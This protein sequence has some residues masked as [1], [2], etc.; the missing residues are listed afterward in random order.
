[1]TGPGADPGPGRPNEDLE[2]TDL[3][4]DRSALAMAVLGLVLVKQL[5]PAQRAHPVV[6]WIV[7]GIASAIALVGFAYRRHRSRGDRPSRLALELVSAATAVIGV[8]AFFVALV[9]PTPR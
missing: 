6:G 4:W 3:A 2:R 1:M 8:A 7:L 5:I 9:P